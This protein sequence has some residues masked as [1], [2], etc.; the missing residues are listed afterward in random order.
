MPATIE[1]S[2][3]NLLRQSTNAGMLP[4]GGR[5]AL[6]ECF[7]TRKQASAFIPQGNEATAMQADQPVLGTSLVAPGWSVWK[8][9][10]SYPDETLR[11]KPHKVSS[12]EH[13]KP[14]LVLMCRP[15]DV[16]KQVNEA[17]GELSRRAMISEIKGE[18]LSVAALPGGGIDKGMLPDT[19]LRGALG[20]EEEIA[21]ADA[22]SAVVDP[23]LNLDSGRIETKTRKIKK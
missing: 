6:P 14:A 17:Y 19:R 13:D 11:G 1:K 20:E 3:F 10:D 9:P 21:E 4:V 2:P 16:Q 7:D 12:I 18:T 15:L 5:F 22:G 23:T 8:Y